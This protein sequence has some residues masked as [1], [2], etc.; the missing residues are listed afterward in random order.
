MPEAIAGAGA[1]L[2]AQLERVQPS[3]PPTTDQLA[4]SPEHLLE[5]VNGQVSTLSASLLTMMA[6]PSRATIVQAGDAGLC[7]LQ[8]AGRKTDVQ[9]VLSVAP[10]MPAPVP[11]GSIAD[12]DIRLELSEALGQGGD[13]VLHRGGTAGC[14]T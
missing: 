6:M 13:D 3:S 10:V 4:I 8:G 11:V 2:A 9:R 14:A 1:S 7:Q 12:G 5:L